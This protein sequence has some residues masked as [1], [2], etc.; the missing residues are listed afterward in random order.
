[1]E[2]DVEG[3]Y[4]VLLNAMHEQDYTICGNVLGTRCAPADPPAEEAAAAA[5]PPAAA[6]AALAPPA[7]AA[8]AA[9]PAV[10]AADAA[11]PGASHT[12]FSIELHKLLPS[13]TFTQI[14]RVADAPVPDHPIVTI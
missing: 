10:A 4:I 3:L 5:A 11:A 12:L 7:A 6:A 2:C 14:T 9:A 13:F 8:A 1:M